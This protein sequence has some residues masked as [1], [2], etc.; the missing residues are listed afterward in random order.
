MHEDDN[1]GVVDAALGLKADKRA[2]SCR[3]APFFKQLTLP[4][5]W[6]CIHIPY[7]PHF[8]IYC[9]TPNLDLIWPNPDSMLI[10]VQT[11]LFWLCPKFCELT[12]QKH[13]FFKLFCIGSLAQSIQASLLWYQWWGSKKRLWSM[14]VQTSHDFAQVVVFL[15]IPRNKIGHVLCKSVKMNNYRPCMERI[16]ST[17][18]RDIWRRNGGAW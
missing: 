2:L 16:G 14:A 17:R 5:S 7:Q 8:D 9:S 12:C 1:L 10:N 6:C 15:V 3:L 13:H 4:S 18:E 11:P